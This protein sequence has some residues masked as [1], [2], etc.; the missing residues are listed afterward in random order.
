[1]ISKLSIGQMRERLTILDRTPRPVPIASLTQAAGEATATTGRA[2]GFVTGDYVQIAGAVPA[3]FNCKAQVT[4]VSA[5]VFTFSVDSGLSTPA[6][7]T[8][9]TLYVS[10]A[11]GGRA[12]SW[13]PVASVPAE[14]VPQRA[15]ERMQASAIVSETDVRFRIRARADVA[16]KMRV[17]WCPVRPIGA[18][19]RL[20][21][22]LGVL[23]AENGLEWQF[24]D[25]ADVT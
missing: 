25:C 22:I 20:L 2:H 18:A 21:E 12:A 3:G 17:R 23:P 13:W 15:S 11:Q 1:M 24:V 6:T 19:T 4:V 14:L 9:T 8:K 16:P 10:D 7:G 5:T